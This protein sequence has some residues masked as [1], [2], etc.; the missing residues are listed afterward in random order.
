MKTDPH[1]ITRDRFTI[2]TRWRTRCF[3]MCVG[4]GVAAFGIFQT[5]HAQFGHS[6][7]DFGVQ[8]NKIVTNKRVYDSYFPTFGIARHFTSNPGFAAE[9][10]GLGTLGSEHDVFYDVLDNLHYWNADGFGIA[11]EDVQIRIENNPPGS[12]STLVHAGSG[13]QLGSADPVR[14]RIGSSTEGG[15]VHSHLNFFLEDDSPPTGAY[16]IQIAITTDSELHSDSDPI[17]LV[18]NY[19]LDESTFHHGLEQFEALLETSIIIGDFNLNGALDVADIDLITNAIIDST[20]DLQFDLNGDDRVDQADRT[21]WIETTR[22]TYL[23][24]ANLDGEFSSSDFVI[25]FQAGEYED[26]IADNS[27]W[28]EGDWNGDGEFNT[29]DFVAAFQSG[30]YEK[31]PRTAVAVPEPAGSMLLYAAISIA[32]FLRRKNKLK[33]IDARSI[34]K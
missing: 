23:G 2:D 9:S 11:Q 24:D 30:G 33:R 18:F 17:F 16:G 29:S 15:E 4:F 27:T 7:I 34:L 21:H 6:D 31:G 1:N 22:S 8:G 25:V 26:D 13:V 32:P 19:G 20:T 3:L 10:D 5:A 28:A 14:N 12:D